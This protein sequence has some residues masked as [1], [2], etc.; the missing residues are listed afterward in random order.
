MLAHP[1]MIT[2]MLALSALALAC[3]VGCG[4][5][6]DSPK[7]MTSDGSQP[8]NGYVPSNG[9]MGPGGSMGNNNTAPSGSGHQDPVM[10]GNSTGSSASMGAGTGP[11][12]TAVVTS[13]G[14]IGRDA[15]APD[16]APPKR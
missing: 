3:A 1:A 16:A 9:T 15:A 10:G 8:T 12:G 2:K 11:M 13:G 14:A 6:A 4:K 7:S 5:D